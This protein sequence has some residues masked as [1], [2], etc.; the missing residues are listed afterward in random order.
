MIYGT[1]SI[2][3]V[4][5]LYVVKV[6]IYTPRAMHYFKI[7]F[8]NCLFLRVPRVSCTKTFERKTC[9]RHNVTCFLT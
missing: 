3:V 4:L 6:S 7:Y 2:T 1:C 9:E 5:L 8:S